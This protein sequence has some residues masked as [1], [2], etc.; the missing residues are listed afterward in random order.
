MIKTFN[1]LLQTSKATIEIKEFG[2][3][4]S[5]DGGSN[6]TVSVKLLILPIIAHLGVV[7]GIC[8]QLSSSGDVGYDQKYRTP[9]T[10]KDRADAPFLWEEFFLSCDLGHVR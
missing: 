2:V 5:K 3:D 9:S 10:W 8:D 1:E 7:Q 6:S 4:I